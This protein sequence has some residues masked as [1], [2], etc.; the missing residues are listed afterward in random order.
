M[1]AN[2]VIGSPMDAVLQIVD[3]RGT[4]M[5]QNDDDLRLDPRVTFTAPDDGTWFVRTFAFP[6]APE[7]YHQLL[8]A[9]QTMCIDSP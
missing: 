2:F 1:Q 6:A 4:V 5:S 7:Q 9:A 8:P 3:A